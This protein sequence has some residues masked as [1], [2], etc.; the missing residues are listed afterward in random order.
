[1]INISEYNI[2]ERNRTKDTLM[3]SIMVNIA[4]DSTGYRIIA[5]TF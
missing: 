1:M 5:L 4:P 3:S 2:I